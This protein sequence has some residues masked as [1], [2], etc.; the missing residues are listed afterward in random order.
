M[1]SRDAENREASEVEGR[2]EKK[3][4]VESRHCAAPLRQARCS[5]SVCKDW[6]KLR[7]NNASVV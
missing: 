2:E 1:S 6:K 4:K 5:K 3:K 7:S